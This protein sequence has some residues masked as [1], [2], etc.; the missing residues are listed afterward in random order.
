[1]ARALEP[2]HTLRQKAAVDERLEAV[3]YRIWRGHALL[4]LTAAQFPPV[5][6]PAVNDMFRLFKMSRDFR[7]VEPSR[8]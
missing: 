7:R 3:W 4:L 2:R 8:P 1:M 6:N 5:P